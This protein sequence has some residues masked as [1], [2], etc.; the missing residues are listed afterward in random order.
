MM[1][2]HFYDKLNDWDVLFLLKIGTIFYLFSYLISLF[3]CK[4]TEF[5]KKSLRN[6][7]TNY[8]FRYVKYFWNKRYL[9]IHLHSLKGSIIWKVA[10]KRQRIIQD[11][12]SVVDTLLAEKLM[13]KKFTVD[14][15][16]KHLFVTWTVCH[17]LAKQLAAELGSSLQCPIQLLVLWS[18]DINYMWLKQKLTRKWA[19]N[20]ICRLVSIKMAVL[21]W[22]P[23]QIQRIARLSGNVHLFPHHIWLKKQIQSTFWSSK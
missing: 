1:L 5:L 6:S 13:P 11:D 19:W 16:V 2:L 20:C 14:L 9:N 10:I 15:L 7:D 21:F 8:I 12:G 22:C 18:T 17:K 4:M 3:L 23:Q